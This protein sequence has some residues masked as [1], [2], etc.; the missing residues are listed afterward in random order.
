MVALVTLVTMAQMTTM[1][2]VATETLM[3]AMAPICDRAIRRQRHRWQK[4]RDKLGE[5]DYFWQW[6]HC[7]Y[8]NDVIAT[9][10]MVALGPL[11]LTSTMVPTVFNGN[12][13]NR[14]TVKPLKVFIGDNTM[15]P[16]VPMVPMAVGHRQWQ[17]FGM[18]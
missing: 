11:I 17:K 15:V 14:A 6:R 7:Y 16:M 4:L 10:A 18:L 5:W 8:C 12:F 2:S 13:E 3:M 1:A 9:T